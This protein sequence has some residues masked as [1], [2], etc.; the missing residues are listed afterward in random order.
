MLDI[1]TYGNDLCIHSY[2][3][4]GFDST[5]QDFNNLTIDNRWYITRR[6][7]Y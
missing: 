5:K 6:T 3:S 2:N 7:F 4:S 1:Y